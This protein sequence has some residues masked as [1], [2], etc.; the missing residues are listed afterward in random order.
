MPTFGKRLEA[1]MTAAGMSASSLGKQIGV[2]PQVVN[3]WLKMPEPNLSARNLL[4]TAETLKVRVFWLGAGKGPIQSFMAYE[5]SEAELLSSFRTLGKK[6]KVL[7][8]D[9][10]GLVMRYRDD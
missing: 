6:E 7:V 2:A 4:R 1:A 8:R 5:Y 10:I 9:F 3:R